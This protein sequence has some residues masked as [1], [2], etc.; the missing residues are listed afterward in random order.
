M[1]DDGRCRC[2][3]GA[4]SARSHPTVRTCL[5][6]VEGHNA[7]SLGCP[8]PPLR[9]PVAL[10]GD[11]GPVHLFGEVHRGG[12]SGHR[13]PDAENVE[14]EG[15]A[16]G[17]TKPREWRRRSLLASRRDGSWHTSRRPGASSRSRR[18]ANNGEASSV[19]AAATPE[20]PELLSRRANQQ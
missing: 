11:P 14:D 2:R 5:S 6:D 8:W 18:A 7:R 15:D 17:V 9:C 10:E 16:K 4:L 19:T 1:A 12:L 3:S 13:R 20:D